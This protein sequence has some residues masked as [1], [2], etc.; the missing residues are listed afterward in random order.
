MTARPLRLTILLDCA[1]ARDKVDQENDHR[2]HEQE[3][4]EAASHMEDSPSQ[5]P[6]DQQDYRKPDEHGNSSSESALQ[7]R[8]RRIEQNSFP[9]C[10]RTHRISVGHANF[11]PELG[12]HVTARLTLPRQ[13]SSVPKS[14]EPR[15]KRRELERAGQEFQVEQY[16]LL[17]E[18]TVDYAVFHLS[19]S[20]TIQ[21]W[22]PGAARIF[23]YEASEIIGR[24][25]ATLF[26]PEDNLQ[27]VPDQ[28]VRFA[29]ESGRAEDSRWHLR[30]DG[31]RFWA[32]GVM[33]GLRDDSGLVVGLGKII[34]DDTDRKRADELLQYQLNVAD[35]IATNAAEALFLIDSEGRITFANPIAQ[36]MFGW[37]QD[38]LLGQFLHEK[39]NCR[40]SVAVPDPILDCP[41]MR[42]LASGQTIRSEDD[43]FVHKEGS[44]VPISSSAAPIMSDNAVV[45]AVMVV[46]DLTEQ[47]QAEAMQRENE[48]ALQ[49][50]Q[51]L[52]S[53]GVLAGGIAHDFNNLL[54]GNTSP[55]GASG[56]GPRGSPSWQ[57]STFESM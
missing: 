47:K 55:S 29:A 49:Q 25:G 37:P 22:N 5:Q 17:F 43:F 20:G 57:A 13:L 46:S 12:I 53:I 50:A 8:H 9:V 27:G 31:S 42:V 32:N 34:R 18:A 30:K 28:E 15:R 51:K 56:P 39:L 44:L 14:R 3:V 54:T 19:L 48:E 26:T 36:A 23:G 33:I 38:D 40:R 16:R 6:G 45:G 24:P 52:E 10:D 21:T 41:H 1:P 35:A 11:L 2:D 7:T 4:N